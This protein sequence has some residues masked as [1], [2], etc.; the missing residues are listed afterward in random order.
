M[1]RDDPAHRSF[2]PVVSSY[3]QATISRDRR[4]SYPILMAIV[5]GFE[6]AVCD[7]QTNDALAL[8]LGAAR[9]CIHASIRFGDAQRIAWDSLQLSPKA[10]HG[11]CYR[12]KASSTGQLFACLWH[13]IAGRDHDTPWV[14]HWLGRMA[15]QYRMPRSG[16]MARARPDFMFINCNPQLLLPAELAPASY[17]RTLLHL[18]WAAQNTAVLGSSVLRCTEACELT[19]HSMKT[20]LLACAAQLHMRREDRMAQGHHRDSALLYSRKDLH[21]PSHTA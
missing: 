9:L 10:L 6:R 15:A 2:A 8:L 18:R 17:A 13:G 5:V 19:L 4:E 11:S 3:A 14:L 7:P 21:K 1:L 12:T 16:P 20:T